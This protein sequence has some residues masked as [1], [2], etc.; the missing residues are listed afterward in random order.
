M[1]NTVR[2]LIV[3]ILA[4]HL[5][6]IAWASDQINLDYAEFWTVADVSGSVSAVVGA[7]SWNQARNLILGEQIGA[8][9]LIE[10]GA[11]GEVILVRG[12]D[13]IT[14]YAN[15]EIELP[16]LDR[17]L[18]ITRIIQ[19]A[20][21]ALFRVKTRHKRN[22]E[23]NAPYLVAGVRGTAFGI[24][25]TGFASSVHV[26]EGAVAVGSESTQGPD[27]NFV[28]ALERT[29]ASENVGPQTDAADF[30]SVTGWDD[31][32][33]R[34]AAR[35]D[36]A[37]ASG[38]RSIQEAL[39]D[40]PRSDLEDV[41]ERLAARQAD[42]AAQAAVSPTA[43]NQAMAEMAAASLE[44]VNET[45]AEVSEDAPGSSRE[46]GG[47]PTQNGQPGSANQASAS[48]DDPDTTGADDDSAIDDSDDDSNDSEDQD[49]A[50]N[51]NSGNN[52]NSGSNGNGNSGGGNNSGNGNGN[53]GNNGNSSD[54]GNGNS[55]NSGSNGNGN[56]GNN[57]NGNSGGNGN[58]NGNSGN[59]GNGNSGN[60]GNGNGNND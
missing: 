13:R 37:A 23:V 21:E 47:S 16:P 45:V 12:G 58:G 15:S 53:S 1:R 57:G 3:G 20:G 51:G 60:N 50:G 46:G 34:Q 17:S 49:T 2:R 35:V 28:E 42:I 24:S 25:T 54:N 52:G 10:T 55:G 59:N 19:K 41:T 6:S 4:T 36:S 26:V 31:R 44:R 9:S 30:R 56:S 38:P 11:D 22:F 33:V 18:G 48:Q 40:Q 39:G 27:A 29:T 8:H 5:T 7:N 14:L 32:T 43:R